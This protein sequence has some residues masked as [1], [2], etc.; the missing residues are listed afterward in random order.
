MSRAPGIQTTN[1]SWA[2]YSYNPTTG[3]SRI[4]PECDNCYAE[5]FSLRQGRT[6]SEWSHEN[7][8]E[9]VTQH[10]DRLQSPYEYH[11]P[12]GPGR[13]FV[14]SMTDMFH[15]LVDEAFIQDVLDACRDH[16]N[17]L[18][19][20]LTKRPSRAA[21]FD[22]DWPE[23]TILGTSVGTGPGGEYP[24]TTHRIDELQCADAP[25]RWVSFEPLI[26]RVGPVNLEGIDWIVIG[27]ESGS[28]EDRR[29]MDH[30][31]ARE[32]YEQARAYDIPVWFKQDSGPRPEMNPVLAVPE[33]VGG[34]EVVS[35]KRI[36]EK[37]PLPEITV[38]ARGGGE[39]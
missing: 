36:R 16:P 24:D 13:V 35:Q 20:W 7:A 18:W 26:E 31:W 23:N 1:I 30:D 14:G 27:G 29:E 39:A 28:E 22:L 37:P 21:D 25:A 10:P 3:C 2:T 15:R 9:N 6:E 34:V 12:E 11:W 19:I 8:E 33:T 4:G 5:A 17:Q 38:E 32:L